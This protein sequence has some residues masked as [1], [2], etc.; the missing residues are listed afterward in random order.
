MPD[1]EFLKPDERSSVEHVGTYRRVLPVSLERMYENA[2]DWAHLPHLHDSSFRD[3]ECLDAGSW[4][5]RARTTDA[6]GGVAILELALDRACRRWITRNLD[7]PNKGAE[8][9]THAFDIE[10][11]RVDIVVDFFV[12]GVPSEARAKVGA[13]YARSY[14]RLYDEDVRMMTE[15]QREI[16][17]RTDSLE[18]FDERFDAG[19][20]DQLE[21]PATVDAFGRRYH[22]VR[23]NGALTAYSSVCPHQLGPISPV[24]DHHGTVACPWHGYRFD[25]ASGDCVTGAACRLQPAPGVIEE[26]GRVILVRPDK[27]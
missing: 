9:W 6:R 1:H 17:R 7:G 14:E 23:M 20:L 27:R 16:D 10:P 3:I 24:P 4:G 22:L 11:R 21:L 8:I 15:R 2:L 25:I 18:I 26:D 13:A 5:W 12:P 19:P